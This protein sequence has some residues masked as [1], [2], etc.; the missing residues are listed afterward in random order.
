[1]FLYYNHYTGVDGVTLMSMCHLDLISIK[2]VLEIDLN[3]LGLVFSEV[4]SVT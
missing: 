1:M 3:Q 4:R 2:D